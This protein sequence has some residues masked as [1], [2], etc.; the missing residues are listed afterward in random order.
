MVY[1]NSKP[2]KIIFT[3]LDTSLNLINSE[4]TPQGCFTKAKKFHLTIDGNRHITGRLLISKMIDNENI[5]HNLSNLKK[6]RHNKPYLKGSEISFNISHS[7]KHVVL[8]YHFNYKTGIDIEVVDSNSILI[9][10]T[11]FS[12]REL[13]LLKEHPNIFFDLWTKKEAFLKAIGIGLKS[14]LFEIDVSNDYIIWKNE[15]FTFEKIQID[16][17][18]ICYL[19]TNSPDKVKSIIKKYNIKELI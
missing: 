1:Q 6:G 14:N 5:Q 10:D 19:C 2:I 11:I 18:H 9:S 12:S 13:K 16:N 3:Q 7:G 4:K 8:C 17:E 15:K